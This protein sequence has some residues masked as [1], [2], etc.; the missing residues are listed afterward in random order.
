MHLSDVAMS[1]A[2][3][4]LVQVLSAR[5][6]GGFLIFGS[7]KVDVSLLP[8]FVNTCVVMLLYF[9][10]YVKQLRLTGYIYVFSINLS[11]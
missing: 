3:T 2:I 4:K 8:Y 9:G 10:Q 11:S 7:V 6:L 1:Y 5:A